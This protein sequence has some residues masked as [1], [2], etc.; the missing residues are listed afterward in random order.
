M[1]FLVFNFSVQRILRKRGVNYIYLWGFPFLL[2][3]AMIHVG[4]GS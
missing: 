2:L 1:A 3:Y 4:F